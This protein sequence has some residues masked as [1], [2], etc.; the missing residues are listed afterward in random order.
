MSLENSRPIYNPAPMGWWERN[1]VPR[2]IGCC[3]AQPQI[4]KARSR[5]VPQ[6][7]GDVLELGCGGGINLSF[8][9][10]DRVKSLTGLDPSPG[11][12]DQTRAKEREQRA[13]ARKNM[14]GSGDRSE[15]IRTY[16]FPQNRITDHRI[17]LT[18]HGIEQILEGD[19]D[20]LVNALY[21]AD[22]RSRAEAITR[23]SA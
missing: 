7:E 17:D 1:M 22:L 6:A 19:L 18:V 10:R 4:M 21:E 20:E 23:P 2:L 15:R 9:D 12:L 5:V 3:C 14:I 8:Y 13:D 16:N 11:L